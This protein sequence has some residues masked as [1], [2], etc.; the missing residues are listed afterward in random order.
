MPTTPETPRPSWWHRRWPSALV[1]AA[2]LGVMV[3]ASVA[4]WSWMSCGSKVRPQMATS[5]AM[6][7]NS[8]ESE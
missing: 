8:A 3:L 5:E 7:G 1:F 6:A 4:I 2:V